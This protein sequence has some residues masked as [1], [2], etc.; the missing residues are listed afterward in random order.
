MTKTQN[1]LLNDSHKDF[2]YGLVIIFCI[3]I[4]YIF[5]SNRMP[6][7]QETHFFIQFLDEST[8]VN[9][10]TKTF[11]GLLVTPVYWL[12]DYVYQRPS[13]FAWLSIFSHVAFSLCIYTWINKITC[14]PLVSLS[15]WVFFSPLS[16]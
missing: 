8:L 5:Y 15:L 6:M 12:L 4:F 9:D 3:D 1:Q 10:P 11:Y 2:Y 16:W 13:I 7:P 14:K